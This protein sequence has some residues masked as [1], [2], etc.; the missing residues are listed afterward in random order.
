MTGCPPTQTDTNTHIHIR[1]CLMLM[2]LAVRDWLTQM[3]L[4]IA[5]HSF[6][7]CLLMSAHG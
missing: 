4:M 1:K 6:T 2:Q 7:F 3:K 5:M